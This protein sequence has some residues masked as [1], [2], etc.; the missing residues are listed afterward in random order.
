MDAETYINAVQRSARQ[1][2]GGKE[3]RFPFNGQSSTLSASRLGASYTPSSVNVLLRSPRNWGNCGGTRPGLRAFTGGQPSAAAT[4]RWLWPNGEPIAWPG[5]DAVAFAE[6][7]DGV[8]MP[9]GGALLN[10]HETFSVRA[11]MGNAPE[12]LSACAWYRARM[13]VASG[14]MWYASRIGDMSDWDYGADGA[15]VSR[16]VSGNVSLAGRKGETIT[17]LAAVAD[18]MLYVATARSLWRV[19]GDVTQSLSPVSDHIGVVSRHAWC[20]DGLRF[21]FWGDKGL[22]ALVAGE[23]P[24]A[25]TPHLE[26]V[27]R[28]WRAATL[29]FDSERNGIHV[30]GED[31][32]GNASD[33]FYDIENRALW[34]MQYPSAMRPRSGGLAMLDGKN[35]A[36]FLCADGTF[37]YWD[38]GQS[39]DDGA[40]IVSALALC[41]VTHTTGD[42]ENAF[43]A[44]LDFGMDSDITSADGVWVSG[45]VGRTSDEALSAAKTFVGRVAGGMEPSDASKF[46]YHVVPGW[47]NVVRPRV[48]CNAFSLVLW[49]TGGRWA[50]SKITAVHRG[51]GRIRR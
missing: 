1:P 42:T 48:R 27:V 16:A 29:V 13:V 15:D 36:V 51:C 14:T 8:T 12:S 33:W 20:W 28:G 35:R 23:P 37:R 40:D 9:D 11:A 6:V 47:Q 43:L 50:I 21:W 5:G 49:S 38:E 45:Y 25:M 41:P 19:S 3:I 39:T 30:I 24:V 22:Y 17:A 18:S 46:A 34:M 7:G 26:D 44:E 31:G 4:S 32:D 2:L 10:Q